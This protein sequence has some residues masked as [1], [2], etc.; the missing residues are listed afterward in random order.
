LIWIKN[1]I[2]SQLCGV[3][4]WPIYTPHR[5]ILGVRLVPEAEVNLEILNVGYRETDTRPGNGNNKSFP[6]G[7]RQDKFPSPCQTYNPTRPA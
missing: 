7:Y 6:V 4:V 2:D 5:N 3:Q 1:F